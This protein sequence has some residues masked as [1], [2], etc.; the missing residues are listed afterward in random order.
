MLAVVSIAVSGTVQYN[1]IP[2]SASF[3]SGGGLASYYRFFLNGVGDGSVESFSSPV[4]SATKY[5]SYNGLRGNTSYSLTVHFYNSSMVSLGSNTITVKTPA[6]P[7]TTPPSINS[8]YA[9][10]IS[11][12]SV[13]MYVSA[14]DSSGVSG[15]YFYL[16]GSSYGSMYGS[17]GRYT[18]SGLNAGTTY[19]FG[20]KAY[21]IYSNTSSMVNYSARTSSNAPPTISSWYATQIGENSVTMYVAASDDEFISGYWFYLNGSSVSTT[22]EGNGRYTFYNLKPNTSYTFGVKVYDGDGAQSSL[23][24]YSATTKKNR[25]DEFVWDNGKYSGYAFNV[26]ANEWTRLCTRVNEFRFYKGLSNSVFTA[27]KKGDVFKASH[28]KE[29]VN[30]I[31][32][33]SPPTSVPNIREAGDT[34]YASDINRLKDSLNSIL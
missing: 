26:T 10:S 31:K 16:N 34:I 30:A 20:V 11:K 14:S 5:H 9:N 22:S 12:K 6:E 3:T 29:L 25:P 17:S 2:V 1:Y 28:Y 23:S 32:A 7:D 18:F 19:S 15:F 4:S 33:M 21:D 24:S 8:W 27:V 13:E